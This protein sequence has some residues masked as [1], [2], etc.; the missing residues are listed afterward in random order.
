M[1]DTS[2]G[3]L[4]LFFSF[5]FFKI[6]SLGF[7]DVFKVQDGSDDKTGLNDASGVICSEPLVWFFFVFF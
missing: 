7:I 3:P 5:L 4:G 2:F 1:P 6:F